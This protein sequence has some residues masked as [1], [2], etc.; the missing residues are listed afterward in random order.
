MD[1]FEV[2]VGTERLVVASTQVEPALAP[3]AVLTAAER[4]VALLAVRGLSNSAIAKKRRCAVRTVTNQ[5]QAI[6]R[7]LGIASRAELGALVLG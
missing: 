2:V 4:E 7:K 5:L 6:Y 1:V 3:I